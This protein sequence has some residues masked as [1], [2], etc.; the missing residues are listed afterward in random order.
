MYADISGFW[1]GFFLILIFLPLCFLWGFTLI[2]IFQRDM[3]GWKKALW[4][5]FVILLPLFGM[6]IYFIVRPV[7][8]QDV[9]MQQTYKEEVEFDRAAHAADKLHKLS[10]LRDKGDITQEQFDKQKAKLIKD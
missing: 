3:S 4:V 1:S 9:E 5:L 8:K 10:E 2:D 7:T 6:L